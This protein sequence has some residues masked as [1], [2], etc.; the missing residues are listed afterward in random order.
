MNT[1]KVIK[2]SSKVFIGFSIFSVGYVSVLSMLNPVATMELVDT[3][4]PNTDAISSI[5]GIFGGVGIA[6]TVSLIYL[7]F[8]DFKNGISFLTLFWGAYA[9]SRIITQ[10]VDG[11][12]GDFGNQWLII[13]STLFILGCVLL[14]LNKKYGKVE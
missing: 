2:T 9:I 14:F 10:L 8:K 13:E 4:L 7:M 6:I 3:P 12:L 1:Q 11:P 5:R